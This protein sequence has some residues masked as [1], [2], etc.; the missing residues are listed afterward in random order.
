MHSYYN[1]YGFTIVE[2]LIVVLIIGIVLAVV[3]PN[4]ANIRS[5]SKKTVCINNM[6]KIDAAIDQWAIENRIA[7]G[8][9]PTEGGEEVIYSY[10]KGS[11]PVCP[12]GGTYTIHAVGSEA[13]VTCSYE[14]EGH[15]L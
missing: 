14:D 4:Y 5:N 15:R 3:L 12:S 13:Q 11:R 1:K 2:I 6:R 10:I 9:V 7:S 8:T